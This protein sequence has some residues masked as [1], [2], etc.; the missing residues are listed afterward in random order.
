[1]FHIFLDYEY[2]KTFNPKVVLCHCHQFAWISDFAL[3]YNQ[4]SFTD[5]AGYRGKIIVCFFEFYLHFVIDIQL[6]KM[7][8]NL[9][10]HE[11]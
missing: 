10:L 2:E 4:Q 1:M 6:V 7:E 5:S 3:Y 11:T 8:I 9:M